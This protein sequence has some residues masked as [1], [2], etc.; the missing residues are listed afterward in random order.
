[1]SWETDTDPVRR[2]PASLGVVVVTHG[3]Q[4]ARADRRLRPEDLDGGERG[5]GS[6]SGADLGSALVGLAGVA[7]GSLIAVVQQRFAVIDARRHEQ[8]V[9]WDADRRAAYLRIIDFSDQLYRA[10]GD[11]D[12]DDLQVSLTTDK[13]REALV[14]SDGVYRSHNEVRLLTSSDTVGDAARALIDACKE[15][16]EF[17]KTVPHSD[18]DVQMRDEATTKFHQFETKRKKAVTVFIDAA[19]QELG[20][21]FPKA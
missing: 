18:K 13:D 14:S 2:D 16:Y 10:L 8:V 9:R 21:K 1:V 12:V 19:A 6:V 20:T 4:D 7:V 3:G 15:L 5:A 11:Q 17:A